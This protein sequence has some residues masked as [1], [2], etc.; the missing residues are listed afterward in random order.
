MSVVVKSVDNIPDSEEETENQFNLFSG[1]HNLNVVVVCKNPSEYN[2]E[3]ANINEVLQNS[4]KI[5][6]FFRKSS[7][8]NDLLQRYIEEKKGKKLSLILDC[9]ARWNS[10]IP[11]MEIFV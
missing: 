6:R 11:M 2:L 8:R 3:D 7:V 5:T 4:R 1:D 9:R 10:H